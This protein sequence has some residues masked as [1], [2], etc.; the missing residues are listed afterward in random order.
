VLRLAGDA[1]I[2]DGLSSVLDELIDL[3]TPWPCAGYSAFIC[4]KRAA[5]RIC[6]FD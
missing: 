5:P 4:A 2:R 1:H 3:N 6:S